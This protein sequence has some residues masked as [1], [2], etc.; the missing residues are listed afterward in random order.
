MALAKEIKYLFFAHGLNVAIPLLLIPMLAH[1]LGVEE[2]GHF[3]ILTGSS[4]YLAYAIELGLNNIAIE[5]FA[6]STEGEKRNVFVSILIIKCALLSVVFPVGMALYTKLLGEWGWNTNTAWFCMLPVVT[7]ISY[8]AWLFIVEKKQQVNFYVQLVTKGFLLLG[9][10]LFVRSPADSAV[11]VIIYSSATFIAS[12][13]FCNHW[14]RY[15]DTK[16]I[17]AI[18]YLI[19]LASA[20]IKASGFAVR[21]AW[22]SNGLAPLLGFILHTPQLADFALA[23]KM[24]RALATPA[25]SFGS[26]VL[27]NHSKFRELYKNKAAYLPLFLVVSLIIYALGS[28]SI[29]LLAER[30]FSRYQNVALLFTI[31]AAGVPFIYANY[32][33]LNLTYIQTHRYTALTI[34][35]LVQCLCAL[36]I[37]AW[38]ANSGEWIFAAGSVPFI[39]ILAF[40][41][42]VYVSRRSDFSARTALVSTE[43]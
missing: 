1:R 24:I 5:R 4:I 33:L 10:A 37:V 27:A 21:D 40:V 34:S 2:F 30:Y 17:P 41:C 43:K 8:P 16:A 31:M 7:C 13:A 12:I 23:E 22:S 9:V 26:I 3:V 20:G 6:R 19:E 35:I 38:F 39:E 18:S 14:F 29:I 42:I 28:V 36:A 25:A 32:T 15:V 11:A